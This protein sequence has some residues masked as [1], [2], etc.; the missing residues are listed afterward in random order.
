MRFGSV[1]RGRIKLLVFGVVAQSSISCGIPGP[2][3][4]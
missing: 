1:A 4:V 3:V 2:L